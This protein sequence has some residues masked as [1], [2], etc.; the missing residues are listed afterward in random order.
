MIRYCHRN[1]AVP[2]ESA[3]RQKVLRLKRKSLTLNIFFFAQEGT[4]TI[5]IKKHNVQSIQKHIKI[6]QIMCFTYMDIQFF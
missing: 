4:K 6:T 2:S 3:G 1:I 5:N